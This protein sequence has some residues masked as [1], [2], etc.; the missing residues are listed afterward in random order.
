[1]IANDLD[2]AAAGEL[3]DLDGDGD[4]DVAAAAGTGDR[5]VWFENRTGE[6]DC[7]GNGLEDAFDIA[8][9]NSADCDLDGVPD[10]CQ[11]AAGAADCDGN[12]LLDACE[13]AADPSLDTN[14]NGVLDLCEEIGD[15]YC[16]P[17]VPNSTGVPGRMRALGSASIATNNLM[18]SATSLPANSFGFFLT[19][20]DQGFT[21][22]V[23][24]SQGALCL[25]GAIGRF[26][27]PGEIQSAGSAGSFGLT[28][29]LNALPSPTGFV[30]GATGESWSFQAWYRDANP[31]VTSNLTDGIAVT[32]Q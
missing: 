23:P 6:V 16:S 4:V 12:G 11:I 2:G 26:V 15:R 8:S 27:G 25:G 31:A 17:A 19:S 14:G 28:L 5:V 13:I 1:V 10:E 9:G 30:A 22:P 18:V 24:A 20:R 3:A 29:D 21:F 7:N 32:L